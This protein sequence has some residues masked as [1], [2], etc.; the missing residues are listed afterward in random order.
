MD[1][2]VVGPGELK[3][4]NREGGGQ[5]DVRPERRKTVSDGNTGLRKEGKLAG[6]EHESSP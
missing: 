2:E 3:G 6:N 1:F 4:G 5:I